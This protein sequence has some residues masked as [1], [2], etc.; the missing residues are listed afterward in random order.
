MPTHSAF[1]WPAN[2]CNAVLPVLSVAL[3]LDIKDKSKQDW[4]AKIL[5]AIQI[6]QLILTQITRRIQGLKFSQI[7][8]VTLSFAICG[9]L[10]YCV[11][12]HKPQNIERPEQLKLE[13]NVSNGVSP[14]KATTSGTGVS[15]EQA[16]EIQNDKPSSSFDST[17]D[18]FW[19]IMLNKQ[20]VS[21]RLNS[22]KQ[23]KAPRIPNDSITPYKGSNEAHPAVY[24]LALASG[25]FS[26]IH[27]I[28]WDFEFPTRVEKLLWH[29]ATAVS[30][31]SPVVGL[32][33]IPLAQL[34]ASAGDP[35]IF[36]E[37][38]LRLLKEFHWHCAAEHP[39]KE[40]IAELES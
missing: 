13:A 17:Y 37:G 39:V 20:H 18:S 3:N 35:A 10:I 2:Q 8:T 11:N 19:A 16:T 26:A 25:L 6:L 5:A 32:L 14:G 36:M 22:F 12:F 23:Q 4:L 30:A 38:C 27:A 9:V 1:P 31:A 29:V 33:G 15:P 40:A 34:M 21:V 7:E 24:L 28:A